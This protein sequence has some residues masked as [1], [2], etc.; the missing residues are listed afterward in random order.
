VD[1]H[2]TGKVV[3]VT[4]ASS[5]IGLGAAKGFAAEGARVV[6]ASRDIDKGEQAAAN[7]RAAGAEAK[8]IQCDVADGEQVNA[9]VAKTVETYGRLDAAFNNAGIEPPRSEI[10]DVTRETWDKTIAINLTG[11]WLCVQAEV[12]A[13]RETGGGA[14]VNCSSWQAYGGLS[15]GPAY[16]ASKAGLDGLMR[17]LAIETGPQN[18]RINTLCPGNI[19]TP[20][21]RKVAPLDD[22]GLGLFYELTPLGR[23][24]TVEEVSD[25]AVW[26]CSDRSS[27]V[28]GESLVVG[29]GFGSIVGPMR[30][31]APSTADFRRTK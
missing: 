28:H 2:L 27:F 23:F 3:I 6:L 29:G 30:F 20:L 13:M 14:I 10:A 7:L 9:L 18:I 24:G 1:L 11:V 21:A 26:L 16:C 5:G 19:D 8:F 17:V 31:P 22:P 25:V 15:G 4:G 12:K